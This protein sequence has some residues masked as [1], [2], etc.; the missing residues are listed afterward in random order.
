MAVCEVQKS[1]IHG[2]GIFAT[3]DI[4]AET[5]LFETHVFRNPLW[6]NILPNSQYN[7]SKKNVNCLSETEGVLKFLVTI[8]EIKKGEELLVDFTVDADLEDPQEG[9]SE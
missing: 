7:H 2:F 8:R 3:E 9:W 6:I 5:R 4:P 1:S